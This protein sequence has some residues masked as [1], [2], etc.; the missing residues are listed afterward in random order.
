MFGYDF[1]HHTTSGYSYPL[2]KQISFIAY[3]NQND[4]YSLL[5]GKFNPEVDGFIPGTE[6]PDL[7]RAAIRCV[8]EQ[9]NI[10]LSSCSRWISLG[11]LFVQPKRVL[12]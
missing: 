1:D 4:G 6:K 9:A 11:T 5:G 2:N 10:D 7:I 8:K 3:R 12:W